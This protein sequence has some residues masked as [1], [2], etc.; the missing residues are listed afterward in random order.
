[1]RSTTLGVSGVQQPTVLTRVGAALGKSAAAWQRPECGLTT[2]ERWLVTFTDD[3]SAFV[4]AATDEQTAA[5]LRAERAALLVAGSRFGP[6][7]VDWIDT[8][9]FPILVT[10]DLSAGHW[11]A[12]TGTVHWRPGDME[13]VLHDLDLLKAVPGTGLLRIPEVPAHWKALLATDAL[14]RAGLCSP[15]WLSDNGQELITEDEAELRDEPRVLVHGDVR[16]DNLCV[17]PSG[18]TRFVDWSQ[19]GAGHPL[20]DLITLL[21]TLRLEGGP[22]PSSLLTEPAVLIV[23]MAGAA[24]A[25]A[26]GDPHGPSWLQRVLHE[27][28]LIN[29]QWVCD[30]LDLAPPDGSLRLGA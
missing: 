12:G 20:H 4:K 26:L 8:E 16:S 27:L 1:M 19:A 10:E 6:Q 7:I 18:Q 13:N 22:R 30:I 21:P 28:A 29:F 9:E 11:P 14:V 2:A 5:W 25:R 3:T 23:R 17:L 15:D 24:I